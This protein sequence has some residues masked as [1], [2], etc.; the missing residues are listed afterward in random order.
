MNLIVYYPK[1][2]FEEL[3]YFNESDKFAGNNNTRARNPVINDFI[4]WVKENNS[5]VSLQPF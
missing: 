1:E 3:V 4:R 2:G 5:K